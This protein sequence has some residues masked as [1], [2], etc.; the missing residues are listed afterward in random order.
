MKAL[1]RHQEEGIAYALSRFRDG[2]LAISSALAARDALPARPDQ[3]QVNE[4]A[5]ALA[6]AVA[7]AGVLF[8][9]DM[10]LGKTAAAIVLSQRLR[11]EAG[12]W[13]RQ[14]WLHRELYDAIRTRPTL[15]LCRDSYRG[16]WESQYLEWGGQPEEMCVAKSDRDTMRLVMALVR[17]GLVKFVV[18][19]YDGLRARLEDCGIRDVRWGLVIA[20]E[21]QNI[22][23]P[24]A[25]RTQA[26]YQLDAIFRL[27]LSG[28]PFTNRPDRMHGALTF[29]QGYSVPRRERDGGVRWQRESPI[30]GSRASFERL[31]CIRDPY[32]RIRRGQNLNHQESRLYDCLHPGPDHEKWCM[33]LH[34]RAKRHCMHR[35][36]VEDCYDLPRLHF[37]DVPIPLTSAQAAIYQKLIAGVAEWLRAGHH[38]HGDYRVNVKNVMTQMLYGFELAVDCRQL[39]HSIARKLSNNS[40]VD[41]ADIRHN[42]LA[43]I[44]REECSGKLNWLREALENELDGKV[45]VFTEFAD[46]ARTL[47]QELRDFGVALL[48]GSDCAVYNGQ[49][50][51]LTRQ[52]KTPSGYRT[53]ADRLALTERFQNDPDLRVFIGTEAAY[54]GIELSRA[55]AVILYGKVHWTPGKVYQAINRGFSLG[56]RTPTTV[57][58][59]FAPGTVEAYLRKV[60]AVKQRDIDAALDASQVD[61]HSVFLLRNEQDIMNAFRGG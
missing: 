15:V 45:L 28:T 20:D 17:A 53:V 30:W 47:A 9:W 23:N 21:V 22:I 37:E 31:Y 5:W 33:A 43:S 52:V 7:G 59:L 14:G 26:V 38:Y 35:V 11:Q 29:V 24:N 58:S 1:Y 41:Y 54:E 32:G 57:F 48:T 34:E 49:E 19:T 16:V 8:A 18:M 13:W 6:E 3:H 4:V 40:I 39:G 56:K 42:M 50:E 46:N 61:R 44:A 27:A 12:V 60:L 51:A 55:D 2:A 10:R 25:Q 36:K